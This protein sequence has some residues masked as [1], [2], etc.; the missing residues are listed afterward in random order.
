M[1]VMSNGMRDPLVRFLDALEAIGAEHEE[2]YDTD[3]RERLAAVIEQRLIVKSSEVDV[4]DELGMFSPEGNQLVRAALV[5]YL[6][7][8]A[9]R[10]DALN[11]D[12]AARRA[13]VWDGEAVSTN[14]MP[15]DEFLGWVD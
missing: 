7:E 6:D 14:G 4:P 10:A 13:A 15:V 12:E 5:T 8:A 9:P 3:V 1:P 11:L 2:V